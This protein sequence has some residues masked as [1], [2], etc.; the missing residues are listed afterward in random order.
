M[1][2]ELQAQGGSWE[3]SRQQWLKIGNPAAPKR[4]IKRQLGI[5]RVR[6]SKPSLKGP[7]R[8]PQLGW[9]VKAAICLGS[10][11]A[12]TATPPQLGPR[13][14]PPAAS[15]GREV[16]QAFK[17]LRSTG[18]PLASGWRVP[19]WARGPEAAITALGEGTPGQQT[20]ATGA[21]SRIMDGKAR[22]PIGPG[23]QWFWI[24]YWSGFLCSGSPRGAGHFELPSTVVRWPRGPRSAIRPAGSGKARKVARRP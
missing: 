2:R 3:R 15:S 14:K 9:G 23:F 12:Q 17:G 5:S 13:G 22:A 20:T 6:S 24:G 18:E 1:A 11:Q 21:T 4:P 10:P 16:T 7:E 8:Q 19:G